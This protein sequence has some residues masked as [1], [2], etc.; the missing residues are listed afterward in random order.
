MALKYALIE[1]EPPAAQR[2]RRLLAELRPDA[3]CLA[4]ARDGEAGLHLLSMTQPDV[5][6]LDIEFPPEGAFGLLAKA[7]GQGLSLPP[8]VFVTAF[9]RHAVDA[10]RWSAVDYLLKPLDRERLAE[11]LGRIEAKAAP[12][13]DLEPLLEA[14]SAVKRDTLPERFTLL[15]KGRLKVFSW[16]DVSH[17][18]TENRLLFVH[19][20]EGRFPLDRTLD[21]L[22]RLLAPAFY[23]CHRGAMVALDRV[24][25]L[26]PDAGGTGE[27]RLEGGERVSVSRDRLPELRKRLG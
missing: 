2:L 16:R 25:E 7:K 12:A 27:V 8:I 10:F 14:L 4:E 26:I 9:D 18:S 11:S 24:R 20:P 15:W 3:V 23:R 17:L 21:E 13:P 22:E 5:L 6:F 19:T 1:D